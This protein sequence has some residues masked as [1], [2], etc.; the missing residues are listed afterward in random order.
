[1]NAASHSRLERERH[2]MDVMIGIYC[3][4]HHHRADALCTDCQELL[5][6]AMQRIDKCP[7]QDDRP[8]CAK[9]PIHGYKPAMREQVRLVMRY[10]GPRMIIYHPVQAIRHYVDE[11]SRRGPANRNV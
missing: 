6:Y 4:G 7:Y 5:T 11:F 2:T 1:M 8:T 10:A 9:C 3:R